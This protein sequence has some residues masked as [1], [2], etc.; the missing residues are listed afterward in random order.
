MFYNPVIEDHIPMLNDVGRNMFFKKTIQSIVKNKICLDIG[1]G[2]GIL[3]DYALEFGAK[4]VYCV[5]IRKAK[6]QFLKEKYKGKNVEIIED[7]FLNV[8]IK[9]VESILM[10]ITGC[11]FKNNFIIKSFFQHIKNYYNDAECTA[12]RYRIKAS[13][14]DGIIDQDPTVLI[15][16]EHLPTGFYENC[17]QFKTIRETENKYVYDLSKA[18]CFED[19]KFELDLEHY[20]DA[21][22]FLDDEILYNDIICSCESTYR[23]FPLKPYRIN[24]SEAKKKFVFKWQENKF[25]LH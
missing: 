1:A 19:I 14:F 5:E 17:N 20:K 10:E 16:S 22:I 11:Q 18:N 21:T 3:T 8:K 7:N 4:K 6:A 12:N 13:V 23:H 9:E 2:T 24:V 15:D 25:I